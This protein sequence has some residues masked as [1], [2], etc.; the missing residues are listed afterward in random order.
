[1]L[2]QLVRFFRPAPEVEHAYALYA[3]I[4]EESRQPHFFAEW[5][6]PDTLDGRFEMILLHM[7]M[8]LNALKARTGENTELQRR[9][10]EAFFEDMDRS[11]REM[12][13]GDTGV[14]RRV[15]AMANAF[16]GRIHA[17]TLAL[18]DVDALRAALLKNTFATLP[19][20]PETLNQW[21]AYVQKRAEELL[22]Q[23][24]E[25]LA[26]LEKHSYK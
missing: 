18:P 16:Y 1:M 17:Y 21:I 26:Y 8:Y 9:L 14:G 7:F 2:H 13:I 4:N 12:G 3:H 25:T 22:T 15:K 24:I 20:A 23:P 5:G 10:I 11:M 6:A 19:E